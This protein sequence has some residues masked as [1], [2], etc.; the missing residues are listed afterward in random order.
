MNSPL[1]IG[2][3]GLIHDHVWG[4]LAALANCKD[5][6]PVA[7]SDPNEPLTARVSDEYGCKT[8]GSHE[9][10]LDS[11]QLDAVYVFSSNAEGAELAI[12]SMERKLHVLSEKP[13]A[14]NLAQADRMLAAAEKNEVKLVINWPFAWW[15]QLQV[16]LTMAKDGA[17]GKLWGVKYRAAHA[18]PEE[19][20]CSPYFCNWL[21]DRELNGAGALLD[22][23]GYGCL[24]SAA[25]LGRPEKVTGITGGQIKDTLE[26]EDNAL[27][28]MTYPF[29][30]ATAEASWTQIGKL[31]SYTTAIYGTEGTLLV[32]PRPKGKLF[33][34]TT[35]DPTGSEITLPDQKPHLHDSAS[36]FV[37][38]VRNE[39]EPWLLCQPHLSRNA[40]EIMEAGLKSSQQGKH[41]SLPLK[42]KAEERISE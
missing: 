25:M 1:K 42:E 15:P 38:V 19:L 17:I 2:I 34:A 16:A 6:D 10:L 5:A 37:A 12:Q 31:T 30:I 7:A 40:Q 8:Y 18:G 14:A 27:I 9:E 3:L 36:Q 11:E 13:M 23:C 26:V 41:I 21:F 29:G 33:L 24:L 28:A 32:E 4:N 35:D 22:Y 20:G 39:V